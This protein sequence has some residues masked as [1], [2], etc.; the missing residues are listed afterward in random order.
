MEYAHACHTHEY[1]IVD[2]ILHGGEGFVASHTPDVNVLM[3][4]GTTVI[5]CLTCG[6]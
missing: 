1:S 5:Y 4:V 3:E 2:E 6:A